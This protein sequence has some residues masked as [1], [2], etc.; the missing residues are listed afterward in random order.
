MPTSGLQTPELLAHR[1]RSL[2]SGQAAVIAATGNHDGVED[3]ELAPARPLTHLPYVMH[4]ALPRFGAMSEAVESDP[5]YAGCDGKT[6]PTEAFQS[7]TIRR[8]T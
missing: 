8:D 1:I 7:R 5:E 2:H 3:I 6:P 4:E